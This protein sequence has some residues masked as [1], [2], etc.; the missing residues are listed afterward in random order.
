MGEIKSFKPKGCF[1]T[2][3][4]ADEEQMK[5]G[6]KRKKGPLAVLLISLGGLL[7]ISGAISL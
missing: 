3:L 7:G 1:H 5:Q 6:E 2:T 4:Q